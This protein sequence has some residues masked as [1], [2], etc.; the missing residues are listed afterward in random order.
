MALGPAQDSQ[1]DAKPDP[2]DVRIIL[3]S[4][5]QWHLWGRNGRQREESLASEAEAQGLPVL[6]G[7]GLGVAA[8]KLLA[9]TAGPIAIVDKELEIQR[10]TGCRD[11][12]ANPRI[13]WVDGDTPQEALDALTRWQ[14][15]NGGLPLRPLV[16][17]LYARL[18]PEY[19]KVVQAHL[20]AS[21]RFD[22][23]ARTSYPKC[24]QWPP[25]VLLLTSQYFLL[26]EVV[27][28]FK[29][30]DI[31]HRLL[32]FTPR[33]TGRT[34]FV[35]ELLTAILEFKPDCVL[36]INHLGVD[37]EGVLMDLLEKCRLPL[38]SWFVDNPHLVL[39]V[40]NNLASPWTTIFTW[41]A[42]NVASLHGLGFEHV[43]YLPLG[44]DVHRFR[45]PSAAASPCPRGW[46]AEVSFVGNSMAA[47]VAARLKAGR[48]PRTMLLAYR[49]IARSFGESSSDSVREHLQTDFPNV[50]EDF[51]SLPSIEDRLA[52]ETA[53][54]WEATRIYRNGCIRQILPFSPL[55]AGD[56]Y[57]KRALRD[58]AESWRWHPELNYYADLPRFYPCSAISFNCTSM[59]M[60][61]AVN[62][63]VFDVPA[64]GGFLITDQRRQMDHLFEP[65]QEVVAYSSPEEIPDLVRHYLRKPDARKRISLAARKRIMREHTYDH[66]MTRLLKTMVA[67]YG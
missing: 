66:R 51:Q 15:D 23:W 31:P 49:K 52:Y 35:Q 21:A 10:V 13:L 5:R 43:H 48:F 27:S 29:R 33:E 39:Y 11:L 26:G 36:T 67:V 42:D 63:R 53:I 58:S 64:C 28:A 19:Y 17:P 56:R 20:E 37:R 4:G 61:G 40:Y 41:D 12:A 47:K 14:M 46:G 44:T 45:P 54:T 25:R 57:W 32:E 65:G 60:K 34:E 1:F 8:R 50:F 9:G 38:A 16:M 7:S 30:L 24:R 55:I 59:Q 3:D 62:Q 18:D 2:E 6:L 22:I